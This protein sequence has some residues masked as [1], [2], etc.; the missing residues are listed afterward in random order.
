MS[1]KRRALAGEGLRWVVIVMFL[2]SILLPLIW[3]FGLSLK[4]LGEQF[5]T[6]VHL[7]P[8]NPAWNNYA[9]IWS[10]IPLARYFLNSV[11]IAL[12]TVVICLVISSLA[13]FAMSKFEF[14]GRGFLGVAALFTQ[15]MPGVLFL[16][17]IFIM[18]VMFSAKT[19]IKMVGTYP[20]V[21]FTYV[22]FGVPFSLWMLRSYFDTIPTDLM[23]AAEIDGCSRFKSF[24]KIILPLAAPGIAAT[25][26]Y[27]FIVSWNEVLFATVLTNDATRTYV[28]G[29]REFEQQYTKDYG[30]LM[31]AS[32]VVSMPIV[33][34]FLSFQK[35]IVSGLTSGGVKG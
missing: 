4:S 19:G 33:L 29:L 6:N 12:A 25:A 17:P 9:K 18:F 23:E 16:L 11:I 21:I 8:E 35:M 10:T 5:S 3:M 28:I 27:I 34:L 30:Q 31:A 22:T 20:A 24:V 26:M 32:I 2:L 13:A 14:R 15:L 7:L 1:K